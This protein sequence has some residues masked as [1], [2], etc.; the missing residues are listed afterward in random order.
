MI[1]I[2]D[3]GMGNLRSV[4]KALEHLGVPAEIATRPAELASLDALILPGVG[5]FRDAI[6]ELHRKNFVPAIHE[7]AASGKPFL[8]ICLGMQLLFDRS[9]EDGDYEGLG[10][11]A[12]DVV[13]FQQEPD[14]KIP[15][16][17]WNSLEIAQ[18]HPLLQGIESGDYVYFVHSYHV[19][20]EDPGV[21]LARTHHGSQSFVSIVG[22][23][24]VM[25]TQFHPEKSQRVGLRLL[26]DFSRLVASSSLK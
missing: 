14:L 20:P 13:R 21:V 3:Y 6:A 9:F 16:M 17:G 5:A 18:N 12:G 10:L 15:H 4:Q 1:G 23:G 25:A 7:F 11:I 19:R 8:G 22:R 2:I 26:S 24:N